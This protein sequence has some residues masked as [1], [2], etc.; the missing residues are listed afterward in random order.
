RMIKSDIP[1]LVDLFIHKHCILQNCPVVTPTKTFLEVLNE[2]SWS[3]NVRELENVVERA[4]VM[5]SGKKL[6]AEHLPDVLRLTA[7]RVKLTSAAIDD[8]P[9]VF[10]MARKQ[11]EKEYLL[12]ALH[13]HKGNISHTAEAIGITRR[14]LQIKIKQLN[15][16]VKKPKKRRRTVSP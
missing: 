3:G 15:I 13:K 11:F 16:A 12:S 1:Q 4:I 5:C 6:H 9:P 7:D 8:Y 10:K 14:N 2:H